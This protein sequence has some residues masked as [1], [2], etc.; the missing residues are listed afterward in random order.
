[1]DQMYP[2][3]NPTKTSYVHVI[4]ANPTVNISDGHHITTG[5]ERL[6]TLMPDGMVPVYVKDMPTTTANAAGGLPRVGVS[7]VG[8]GSLGMLTVMIMLYNL[9]SGLGFGF[10]LWKVSIDQRCFRACSKKEADLHFQ[11]VIDWKG[12][13]S[14]ALTRQQL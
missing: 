12:N 8:A 4:T 2:G 3:W 1:M 5:W 6:P 7:G 10:M 14:E 11:G 13:V 9:L